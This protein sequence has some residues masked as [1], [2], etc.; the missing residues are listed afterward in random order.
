[1]L[2]SERETEETILQE[3]LQ[4]TD[5]PERYQQSTCQHVR[6]RNS[7]Q[8]DDHLFSEAP[9]SELIT[10]CLPYNRQ[11]AEP[12]PVVTKSRCVHNQGSRDLRTESPVFQKVELTKS[13]A[14]DEEVQV[15]MPVQN[16]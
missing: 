2:L 16:F 11:R 7:P 14:V 13:G 8:K 5:V 6:T 3:Q 4:D 15:Q 10:E 12:A 9:D 1:M